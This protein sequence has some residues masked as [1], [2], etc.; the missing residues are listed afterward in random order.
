MS[1]PDMD[2]PAM[3]RAIRELD[4]DV[5]IIGMSGLMNAEQTA[6]LQNLDV[7]SFLTKPFTAEKLLVAISEV[8]AKS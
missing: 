1:M 4:P 6:E 5:K 8:I 3:I 2:G 7:T